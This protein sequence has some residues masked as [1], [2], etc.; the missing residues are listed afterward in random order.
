MFSKQNQQIQKMLCEAMDGKGVSE[1]LSCHGDTA[2]EFV[3]RGHSQQA[4]GR[5]AEFSA[6]AF[7]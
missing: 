5:A 1:L 4:A 3:G 7:W 2:E 6:L